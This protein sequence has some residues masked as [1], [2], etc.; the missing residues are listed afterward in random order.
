MKKTQPP[1]PKDA[2]KIEVEAG[3]TFKLDMDDERYSSG[4]MRLAFAD[5]LCHV[6][7]PET[8]EEL[9][10]IAGVIGGGISIRFKNGRDW[11][12]S[13]ADLWA[14]ARKADQEY[15]KTAPDPASLLIAE[16]DADDFEVPGLKGATRRHA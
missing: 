3:L 7:N 8:G 10:S 1:M 14:A 16:D 6:S 15:E 5:T 13:P 4:S 2:P 11:F 12:L 9:G